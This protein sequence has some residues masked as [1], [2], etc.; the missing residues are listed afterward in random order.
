M[1]PPT[2]HCLQ[3]VPPRIS[4]C[5]YLGGFAVGIPVF[6]L[7]DYYQGRLALQWRQWMTQS[8]LQRYL[9]DRSFYTL[10]SGALVDNPDQRI[11]SGADF[12]LRSACND[13]LKSGKAGLF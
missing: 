8:L 6:V 11:S 4:R 10:Q 5:R 2:R 7:R 1:Q 3:A 12:S 9:E 13:L